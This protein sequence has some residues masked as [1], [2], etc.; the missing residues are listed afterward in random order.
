MVDV[1]TLPG[2][3]MTALNALLVLA[4]AVVFIL[5]RCSN[6]VRLDSRL[7]PSFLGSVPAKS[8]VLCPTA[9]DVHALCV[10]RYQGS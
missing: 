6:A 10:T 4:W 1:T 8:P 2:S 5:A 9:G 7:V 3:S